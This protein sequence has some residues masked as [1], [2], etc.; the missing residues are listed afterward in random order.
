LH[1]S[2]ASC[3]ATRGSAP[4]WPGWKWLQGHREFIKVCDGKNSH[5][6]Y[7]KKSWLGR[8]I[9]ELEESFGSE[10]L[11]LSCTFLKVSRECSEQLGWYEDSP[12]DCLASGHSL[13][14]GSNCCQLGSQISPAPSILAYLKENITRGAYNKGYH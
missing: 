11:W 3:W 10:E 5:A 7:L 14:K 4:V 2:Q 8:C 9:R 13:R 6:N 1:Q 12:R